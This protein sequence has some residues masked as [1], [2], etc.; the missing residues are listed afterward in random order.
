MQRGACA[1]AD[2]SRAVAEFVEDHAT[3]EYQ[4]GT[5]AAT[6]RFVTGQWQASSTVRLVRF[7]EELSDQLREYSVVRGAS[8]RRRRENK[9]D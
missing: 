8:G 1:E 2:S 6:L 9:F 5:C 4:S 7:A 3:F